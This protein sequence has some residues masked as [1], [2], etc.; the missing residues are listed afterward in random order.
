MKKYDLSG[1]W[2]F[3]AD[4]A[5]EGIEKKFFLSSFDDEITLPNTVSAAKKGEYN[6]DMS[7]GY[8]NDPYYYDGYAWFSRDI[9]LDDYSSENVYTLKL[10]RTRVS[11]VWIDGEY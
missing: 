8:L 6:T 7:T 3:S 2:S 10:E 9:V 5:K 1:S 11:R 4:N